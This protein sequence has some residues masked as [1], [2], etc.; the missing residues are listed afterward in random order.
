MPRRM[1]RQRHP[2]SPIASAERGPQH[3]EYLR[4]H[5]MLSNAHAQ[6]KVA[7]TA[8]AS[9]AYR[10]AT[11]LMLHVL[12][13]RRQVQQQ[14][15]EIEGKAHEEESLQWQ[16]AE[17]ANGGRCARGVDGGG[18]SDDA[19]ARAC[20]RAWACDA[21]ALVDEVLHAISVLTSLDPSLQPLVDSHTTPHE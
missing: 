4:P 3:A 1:L 5:F 18:G 17:A 8:A 11:V 14:Q 2:Y 19:C 21:A 12:R 20:S 15:A 16:A 9:G 13:I 6:R 10:K 7:K